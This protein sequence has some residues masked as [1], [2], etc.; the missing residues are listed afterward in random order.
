VVEGSTV[1]LAAIAWRIGEGIAVGGRAQ[2]GG[3]RLDP[4]RA[5][6]SSDPI[7]IERPA[8]TIWR[9]PPGALCEVTSSGIPLLV[10]G[11]TVSTEL[12]TG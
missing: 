2:R 1:T 9:L 7:I 3:L 8:P 10:G 4:T 5:F 12:E 6:A 11:A